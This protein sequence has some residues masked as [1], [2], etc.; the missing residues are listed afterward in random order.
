LGCDQLA[1]SD[2]SPDHMIWLGPALRRIRGLKG[3]SDG[4]AGEPRREPEVRQR[5]A[6]GERTVISVLTPV[7]DPALWM[8]EEAIASVRSQS[9]PHW[10][11][12]LADDG[13]ADP[14]VIA[15]LRR[16]AAEDERIKLVRLEQAGGIAGATN[17]ALGL[18]TGDY[19]ALLDHDD[20][21]TP[22]ALELVAGQIAADPDLDMIY[23]D[24]DIV[25]ENGERIWLHLK[26]GWSPETICTSGYT[27]H[28]GVY[29][30]SLAAQLGGFR[31]DLNGSQDYDFI[32]RLVER[33]DRVAHIPRV[34]Y[35]WRSHSHSTAGGGDI[36][37]PYAYTAARRAITEHLERRGILARVDLAPPGLYRVVHEVH[38]ARPVTVV[39]PI[40]REPD[41]AR[42]VVS[43]ATSLKEQ[44]HAGWQLM[45]AGSRA[46]LQNTTRALAEAGI[47]AA[48]ILAVEAD[49]SPVGAANSA[50]SRAR[51]DDLVLMLEPHVGLTNDWLRRLVGY[52][53]E[54]G[55]A[56]AGPVVLSASGRIE[57]AGIALGHGL[58]LCLLHG[59]A[60]T[61][62]DHHFGFGTAAFNVL[63]A[64][65]VIAT[66]RDLFGSLNGLHDEMGDL[67][68]IDYCLRA[69]QD[70]LRTVVVA[71]ARVR[72][73]NQ[74]ES[75]NDLELLWRFQRTWRPRI[76][77]DPYYN[78]NYLQD[79][80]DFAALVD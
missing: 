73:V 49:G 37:K 47:D 2:G 39:C 41:E 26:P 3:Q 45:I 78:P 23:S 17:A 79:R 70:G 6:S 30:R 36:A 74:G 43:L 46:G 33:T 13:S 11:L 69:G 38:P 35:H 65:G 50:A 29:R 55:V 44:S 57:Q 10:E 32:L 77:A 67:T 64:G 34:L 8:L 58:P 66:R 75:V 9:Y 16:H 61:S 7:H 48:R 12:C 54:P 76:A 24:E 60:G 40:G 21:L 20:M 53:S 52:C 27:C 28:L 1:Q 31:A 15:A 59:D 68:L 42:T 72:T 51:T 56:A 4:A 22:E 63:A 62:M 18:A 14:E 80:G 71:D 25:T 19:I 5:A